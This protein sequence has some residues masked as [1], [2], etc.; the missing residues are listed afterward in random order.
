MLAKSETCC[1]WCG[2]HGRNRAVATVDGRVAQL[3]DGCEVRYGQ[4]RQEDG[5]MV[6]ALAR[7]MDRSAREWERAEQAG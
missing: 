6:R 7:Q 4:A 2:F 1:R 3:C 5:F